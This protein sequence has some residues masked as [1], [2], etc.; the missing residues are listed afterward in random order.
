MNITELT[1][2]DI[3]DYLLMK[4]PIYHGRLEVVSF[5]KR[6]FDLTSMP[7]TDSRFKDAA[8]DMWQHMVNNNDWTD[9]YLLYTYLDL[10]SVDDNVFLRFV[11]ECVHP[12]VLGEP[13]VVIETVATLN[14]YLMPDGYMLKPVSKISGRS[15]YKA[16]EIEKTSFGVGDELYEVVLSY[17]SEDRAYVE[18]VAQYLKDNHVKIFYDKYEEVTLWGKDLTEHLGKIY[19]GTAR[20]CV[21]FISKNYATKAWTRHEWRSAFAKAIHEK[22]EYVLPVRFDNTEIP[23]LQ[24]SIV[25]V[26]VSQKLPEQLGELILKKLGR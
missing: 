6:V 14:R 21:M 5:V 15:I 12:L 9:E 20:F 19:G 3:L 16:V 10:P 18:D 26:D 7:S 1:R 25:Y 22:S 11:E 13:T 2:K 23:G 4:S 17:A 8:G 24:S